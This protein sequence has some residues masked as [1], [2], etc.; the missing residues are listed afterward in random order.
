MSTPTGL[1][2]AKDFNLLAPYTKGTSF[3]AL[4]FADCLLQFQISI[5]FRSSLLVFFHLSLSVLVHY[6]LSDLSR[7]RGWFPSFRTILH[8]DCLTRTSHSFKFSGGLLPSV[9]IYSKIFYKTNGMLGLFRVRSP[10]LTETLLIFFPLG[11]EMFHFPK[12]AFYKISSGRLKD[13]KFTFSLIFAY[14]VPFIR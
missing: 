7:L 2:F 8:I 6:C 9:V 10:L 12:L 1:N 13:Y 5:N 14:R 4:I 11:T 3:D